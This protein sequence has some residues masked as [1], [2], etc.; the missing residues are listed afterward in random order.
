MA[1]GRDPYQVLGVGRDAGDAEIRR[2]YRRLARQF[3][4]DRNKGDAA[5]EARFKEVQAA[6][7]SIGTAEAREAQRRQAFTGFGGPGGF[8]G[9][10]G[11]MG[12]FEDLIGQM[13]GQRGGPSRVPP[14][15]PRT[16]PKGGDV[17]VHLDLSLA[18]ATEGGSFPFTVRR[19]RLTPNGGVETKAASLR[20][21][22]E[23]GRAH[24]S[25]KRLRGQG[26]EH[27]EGTTGDAIVTLRVD[28][29]EDRRWEE[30]RLVQSVQVA[31]ST[32]VLGGKVEATLPD[33]RAGRLTVPEGSLVGDRRRMPG[34]GYAGGDLDLEFELAEHGPLDEAQTKAITAL[35]DLGL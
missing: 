28:P 14:R 33:G 30:G 7:D 13:F 21:T 26:H 17:T 5:A 6:Y 19:L 29:G 32:L 23:P 24:G 34:Q 25:S 12:Q 3:H 16:V 2:A 15:Q 18:Q 22:L 10:P 8:G 20:M 35:R 4:P 9:M 27:P 1:S 31:Y 11:G